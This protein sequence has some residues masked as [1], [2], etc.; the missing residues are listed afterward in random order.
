MLLDEFPAL[1][2][3]D[4]DRKVQ[5]ATELIDSAFGKVIE[6]PPGL[7]SAIDERIAYNNAHPEEVSTTAE[8]EARLGEL[9]KR[10]AARRAHA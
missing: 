9:K 7:L 1:Q 5:L 3:L 2:V 8:F 6:L 10:L 4:D